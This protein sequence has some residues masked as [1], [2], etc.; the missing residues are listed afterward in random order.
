MFGG[1]RGV[2]GSIRSA[3]ISFKFLSSKPGDKK[4]LSLLK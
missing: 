1:R 3:T 4:P 2:D